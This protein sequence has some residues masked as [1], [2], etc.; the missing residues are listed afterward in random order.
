MRRCSFSRSGWTILYLIM[1]RLALLLLFILPLG[2]FFPLLAQDE[3]VDLSKP[4]YEMGHTEAYALF[5]EN[6]RNKQYDLANQ[7][8]EW[9]L[10]AL[11]REIDKIPQFSLEKQFERFVEVYSG[12]AK[13]ETDPTVRMGYYNK[14][15]GLFRKINEVFTPDE[16]DAFQWKITKGTFFQQNYASIPGALD[17]TYAAYQEAFD[18]DYQRLA[19]ISDG[20][21]VRLLIDNYA[22]RRMK[23]KAFAIID[24]VEPIASPGLMA[25]I[26]GARNKL[27]DSPEERIGFLQGKVQDNPE[28]QALIKE[29]AELQNE[30]GSRAE[31]IALYTRLYE[32]NPS[33]DNIFVLAEIE[34]SDAKYRR[35]NELFTEALDKAPSDVKKKEVALDISKNYQSLEELVNA[36]RF[37]RQASQIDPKWDQPFL[38]IARIYAAAVSSCTQGRSVDREDR[39]VYWLVLDYLDKAKSVNPS[40]SAA[41]TRSYAQYEAAMPSTEDKFFNSWTVGE[42]FKIDSGVNECYSWINESTTIR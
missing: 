7:F 38:E 13:D 5:Y 18:L 23:E 1:K 25:V 37:A 20:Y 14:V 27:F 19:Q 28:D 42:S 39:T 36:R 11:P 9:M 22:A 24:K 4:P 12:L 40:L 17:S 16:I 10:Y 15:Q 6:Y 35:S 8:G 32:L 34:A 26:D 29:L 3:A 33:F 2:G 30:V 41:F 21:Y 31:A